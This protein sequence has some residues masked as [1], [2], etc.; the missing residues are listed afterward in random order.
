MECNRKATVVFFSMDALGHIHPILS[1]VDELI[2]RNYRAIILTTRPLAMAPKFRALG[3]EV[4]HCEEESPQSKELTADSDQLMQSIMEPLMENFRQGPMK[5]FAATYRLDGAVGKHLDDM[6]IKHDI[7]E[8]KLKSFKPDLVVFDHVIG[9]PCIT[10]V[11]RRWVRLYSGFPS[12]LFSS[13]NNNFV[14]G[15]GLKLDEMTAE[16]KKTE[17]EIKLPVREK[18]RRFF[19]EKR[20]PDWPR[21]LDLTPTSPYLNFYLGPKELGLEKLTSFAPLPDVWFRLEHTIK[22]KSSD[23]GEFEIPEKLSCLPGKLIYFSLG[24]LVTSDTKLINRLLNILS[25]SGNKFIVSMGQMQKHIKLYP[26]MWGDKFV[27]QKAILPKVDL[28]I[29]HGGHNSVIESFY[30]GVPG[31]IVLPVFADQ[32]DSAQRIEDCGFGVRLNPF[33][34]TED[35]LLNA[36]NSLLANNMLKEQMKTIGTR[37][38]SIKYHQIAVDKMIELLED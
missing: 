32:F 18:V 34:C 29:T 9:T 10:T 4:D 19:S 20:C 3:Y 23:S 25:K 36:I 14:A 1:I 38:R 6:I 13:Y 17:L 8:A 22:E 33:T 27:D 28:F 5:S 31:L 37:L 15:L 11:A 24:T 7:I 21:D 16:M 30:Y 35:E 2:R 26:N 12:A